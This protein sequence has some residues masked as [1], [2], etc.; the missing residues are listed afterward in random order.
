MY[1][2][3]RKLVISGILKRKPR[4]DSS[5]LRALLFLRMYG[6]DFTTTEREKIIKKISNTQLD[7]DR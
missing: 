7:S 1:D 5:R 4:L 2:S 3:G 6:S